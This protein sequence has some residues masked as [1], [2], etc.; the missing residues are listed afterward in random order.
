MK[1]RFPELLDG[2]NTTYEQML[3]HEVNQA[4]R[5]IHQATATLD[6]NLRKRRVIKAEMSRWGVK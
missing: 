3:K 4:Q 5:V 2:H 1:M 6:M